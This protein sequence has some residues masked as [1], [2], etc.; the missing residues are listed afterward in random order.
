MSKKELMEIHKNLHAISVDHM[1]NLKKLPLQELQPELN[2][3]TQVL[4]DKLYEIEGIEGEDLDA[5]TE[6]LG[7]ESDAEY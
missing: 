3:I 7:L 6:K 5:A 1:R 4:S 2:L